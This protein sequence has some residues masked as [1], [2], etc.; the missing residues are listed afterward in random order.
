MEED[1]FDD[2][3]Q[4]IEQELEQSRKTR[5]TAEDTAEDRVDGDDWSEKERNPR[6]ISNDPL[7]QKV[8]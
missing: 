5:L 1:S 3:A 7:L 2:I 6:G 4:L 8:E